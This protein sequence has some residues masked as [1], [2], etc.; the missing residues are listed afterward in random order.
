MIAFSCFH[1]G[2]RLKA[3]PEFAG[4]FARCPTCKQPLVV[5]TP[6]AAPVPVPVGQIDGAASSLA[7]SGVNAAV[8]LQPAAHRRGERSLDELLAAQGRNRQCYVVAEEIA[9]G[10]M[11]AV[12]R[13]VDCDIR[14]CARRKKGPLSRR[15]GASSAV[16]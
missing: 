14:C 15:E 12:L 3:R 5:P 9:R 13:A 2:V 10:G 7:H 16:A 11:G 6:D 1:C 4:R 8:T